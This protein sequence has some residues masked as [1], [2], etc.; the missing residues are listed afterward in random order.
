MKFGQLSIFVIFQALAVPAMAE[1][2]QI[3]ILP[4]TRPGPET[5]AVSVE[6]VVEEP[7][8]TVDLAQVVPM[9]RPEVPELEAPVEVTMSN[10]SPLAITALAVSMVPM[11]RPHLVRRVVTRPPQQAAPEPE[12][13]EKIVPASASV[14]RVAPPPAVPA[15]AERPKGLKALFRAPDKPA[16][17]PKKGSVCGDPAIRGQELPPI[18]AKLRGCGLQNPVQITSVDGIALS[19]PATVS[20]HT[21]VALR[22]WVTRTV[23]PAVGNTG[24]GLTGLRVAASYSCRTR[25]NVPGAKIS[26]HGRG[27]AIDISG[28]ILKDGT[29]MSILRGWRDNVGGPILRKIHAQAC[30][31]FGTVL[32]P[33]SDRYHQDHLHLDVA[34]HGYGPYCR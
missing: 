27:N 29:V 2:P 14:R 31:T 26:E 13:P 5:E 6:V 33:Q 18:P 9:L 34:K 17:Y 16:G 25:N 15:P 32:G 8:E 4:E 30:G 23:K 3:S 19:T 11:P 28:L 21:A 22:S 7:A 12:A 20:C 24:G 1:A 10:K